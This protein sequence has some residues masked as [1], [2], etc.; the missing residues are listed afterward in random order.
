MPELPEVETI[1]RQLAARLP[2]ATV[3]GG[4]G[5]PSEKF[6]SATQAIGARITRVDRRGKY[7]LIGLHNDRELVVHLGMTG[8]FSLADPA[9]AAH[10]EPGPYTRAW[11]RLDDDRTLVFNDIRRFGRVAVVPR[12]AYA[13]LPTLHQLGP[14]PQDPSFS[15]AGLWD[16]LR[17][18]NQRLK[19]QVLS[20]RPVAGVGNI[21][22]DEAFWLAEVHPAR[23][24]LTRA[25]AD[26]LH[27]GI[28][29]AIEQGL[30]AGGTTL[31]DY[32]G[33]DGSRGLNQHQL[34]CYGRSGQACLRCQA[35]LRRQV[36][37]GRSTTYCPI[38][39]G[40][41]PRR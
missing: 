37:D 13:S 16:A 33:V 4:D 23:R 15:A 25:Q 38:C 29:A 27:A 39:Q 11:W 31:R 3:V 12:G 32:Q 19:T 18:T 28:I 41:A 5:H 20:Q 21:Y 10:F 6:R 40:P 7:L 22:A 1:R 26:R 36:W 30:A 2:G 9:A 24:S 35:V 8:S 14:E 34:A 17:A